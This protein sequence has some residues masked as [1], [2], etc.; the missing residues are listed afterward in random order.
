VENH[1]TSPHA[2][3]R[4]Y[5][6]LAGLKGR[7]GWSRFFR[8]VYTDRRAARRSIDRLLAH[9]FDRV[10]LAHGRVLQSG[11]REAVRE[12]YRW[13]GGESKLSKQP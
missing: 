5:L 11:G 8:L 7:V 10:I 3:T 13:L 2:V 1:D 12:A 4:V 6:R 9:D